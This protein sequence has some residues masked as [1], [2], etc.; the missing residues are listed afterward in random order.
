M[1]C[2]E[3][4]KQGN[5]ACSESKCDYWIDYEK[6][7]NCAFV[8]IDKNGPLTLRGTADRLG[9]SYVRVQQIEQRAMKKIEK[10]FSTQ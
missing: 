8:C 4:K 5:F 6:D 7:L 10:Y 2:I 1:K 3:E 9:V